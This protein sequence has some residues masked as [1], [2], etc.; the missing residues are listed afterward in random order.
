MISGWQSEAGFTRQS[1]QPGNPE[2][3][4]PRQEEILPGVYEENFH[5][6]PQ[7][8]IGIVP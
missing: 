1:G 6:N 2:G 5:V 8:D 3:I 7:H 4:F